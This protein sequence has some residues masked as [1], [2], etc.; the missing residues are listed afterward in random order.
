[1]LFTSISE[2]LFVYIAYSFKKVS[3]FNHTEV[4]KV[5]MNEIW[6]RGMLTCFVKSAHL[7]AT[8]E[9]IRR[10]KKEDEGTEQEPEVV[11]QLIIG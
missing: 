8:Q 6:I 7:P 1:M 4:R 5:G 2:H 9:I 11:S 3:S 10:K